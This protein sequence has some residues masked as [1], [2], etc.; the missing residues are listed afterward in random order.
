MNI[1]GTDYSIF[2]SNVTKDKDL[3]GLGGYTDFDAKEIVI[4]S[5]IDTV[6]R[7]NTIVRHEIIHAFLYESGLDVSSWGRNEEIV[8]W[9]ALQ[10]PKLMEVFNELKCI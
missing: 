8:D 3:D 7:K 5:E 10:F 9:I 4:N 2:S 1:L 6:T